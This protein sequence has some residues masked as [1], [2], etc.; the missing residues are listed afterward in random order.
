MLDQCLQHAIPG[1]KAMHAHTISP[2]ACTGCGSTTEKPGACNEEDS[3]GVSTV[4]CFPDDYTFMK[5][6]WTSD[7]TYGGV[8][9]LAK[10]GHVIYGPYN[11]S[12][13][14]WACGD[15]DVC[16]G[17]WLDDGS[18]GYA[19]TTF[20]PYLVGCWGPGPAF[21]ETWDMATCTSSGCG[22]SGVFVSA[23]VF[24]LLLVHMSVF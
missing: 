24:T 5:A 14:L 18:Y 16:N 4:D 10:D 1:T 2:C 6:G 23:S 17:F 7:T 21:D 20:F 19:S 9:G 15:V 8:Y 3:D 13:E 22:N 12:G 11:G